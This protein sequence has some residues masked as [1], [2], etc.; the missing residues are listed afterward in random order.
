MCRDHREAVV[1]DFL[2]LSVPS[3]L[4]VLVHE[5]LRLTLST[6]VGG[7]KTLERPF[8]LSKF[9]NLEEVD[10]GVS[11]V[12]GGL[13]WIHTALSTLRPATSPR[14]SAVQLNFT[15]SPITNQSVET[16]IEETGNDLRQIAA[17]VAR[18][19]C[20]F[21]GAANFTVVRDPWFKVV[22]DALD[23]RFHFCAVGNTS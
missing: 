12:G 14:L 22:L 6:N 18:I 21:K 2:L 10:F 9:P 19:E 20:E 7:H 15:R 3:L 5:I 8:D 23:V 13:L 11:W 16:A 4:P 17:E 1:H